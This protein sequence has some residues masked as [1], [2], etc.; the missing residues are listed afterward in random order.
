MSRVAKRE[1]GHWNRAA[2]RGGGD[3][4][5]AL[6]VPAPTSTTAEPI[7]AWGPLCAVFD[8]HDKC[9]GRCACPCHATATKG[10]G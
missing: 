3:R 9:E 5:F 10:G 6:R 8:L 1:G 7:E 2:R 4:R